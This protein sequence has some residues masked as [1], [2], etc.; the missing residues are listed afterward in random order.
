MNRQLESM[1][2]GNTERF[3]VRVWRTE[4]SFD[5]IN[6]SDI[7][8]EIKKCHYYQTPQQVAEDLEKIPRVAAVEVLD[9][10]GNGVLVYPDWK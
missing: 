5:V 4:D 10:S 6:N 2:K 3:T 8:S 9:T 7:E 1:T